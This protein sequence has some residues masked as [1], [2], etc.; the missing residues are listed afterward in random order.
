[1][2]VLVA[3]VNGY[4]G[5]HLIPVLLDRGHEVLCLVRDKEHF[6]A[7]HRYADS[8]GVVSGDLLRRQSIQ[9]MPKDI[10]AAYY[11]VNTFTQT[12]EFSALG[13]LSA[14]NFMEVI[15]RTRCRQIITLSDISDH[16]NDMSARWLVEELLSN[17]NPELT[18]FNTAM[19]IG[20]GS[21]AL[22]MFDVLISRSP[23]LLPQNWVKTRLQPIS[24]WDV[25]TYLIAALMNEN[26]YGKKFDIGG[27]EVLTFKQMLLTYI[28]MRK[29]TKPSIVVLPFLTSQL[30]SYLLNTLTPVSYPEAQS[31]IHNLRYN[32]ICREGL[33]K[34]IIPLQ[35]STF[36]QSLKLASNPADEIIL[37]N[38][39]SY[40]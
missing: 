39:H 40:K 24:I 7:H 26:T 15:D 17:C 1:M 25:L 19:I 21:T 30:S 27:P 3:G 2:K 31:L 13:A 18:V 8:V 20:R 34:E 33:V 36:K 23:I 4:I 6:Y 16:R 11:L 28:A 35:C 37:Q 14:Q 38:V 32:T 12:S 22:E 10:D 5:S 29:S 9:P